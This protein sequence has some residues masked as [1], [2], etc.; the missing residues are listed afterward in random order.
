MA[1]TRRLGETGGYSRK[2][3]N[4][5][6]KSKR[7][8]QTKHSR[9]TKRKPQIKHSRHTKR[10]PQTKH[11][12]HTKRKPQVKQINS[13]KHTTRS[14]R[15]GAFRETFKNCYIEDKNILNDSSLCKDYYKKPYASSKN[16]SLTEVPNCNMKIYPKGNNM[17]Y[18]RNGPNTSGRCRSSA[19]WS[20]VGKCKNLEELRS[21]LPTDILIQ[22]GIL[23][24]SVGI[25]AFA[26]N[27]TVRQVVRPTPGAISIPL[28]N[29]TI[30]PE[31]IP[32]E[33]ISA[34]ASNPTVRQVV[35]PTPGA[36]PI[37]LSNIQVVGAQ[38]PGP[39]G[40]PMARAAV[41]EIAAEAIV[42][43]AI[44]TE[45]I[46]AKAKTANREVGLKA[47]AVADTANRDVGLKAKAVAEAAEAAAEEGAEEGEGAIAAGTLAELHDANSDAAAGSDVQQEARVAEVRAQMPEALQKAMEI[48]EPYTPTQLPEAVQKAEGAL[49][50]NKFKIISLI[51][52]AGKKTVPS[53]KNPDNMNHI[54]MELEII[55]VNDIDI[56]DNCQFT[57]HI[58]GPKF[59][60]R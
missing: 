56:L 50:K 44:A 22:L 17:Y 10:K 37:P 23:P 19:P 43:E 42:A 3:N 8:P 46:K 1:S 51:P 24:E 48:A 39:H 30:V 16:T 32:T 26:S 7:K 40:D 59:L 21:Y 49:P 47:K 36:I 11:S 35:R 33:S 54:G 20:G 55:G 5:H 38:Q 31:T 57:L 25:S 6:S 34:F 60:M 12:R 58:S 14:R 29:I 13:N 53:K 28:S 41:E 45:E 9:H 18:C 2:Y 52:K 4:S 15:A 27:P